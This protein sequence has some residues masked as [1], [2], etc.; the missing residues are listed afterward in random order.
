MTAFWDIVP[1]SL[2]EFDR[3][4]RGAY[5]FH[6]QA[7]ALMVEAPG[8]FE[9]SVNVYQATRRSILEDNHHNMHNSLLNYSA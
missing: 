2:A 7:I 3:S 9:K 8:I 6:H 1:S 5:C 4:F